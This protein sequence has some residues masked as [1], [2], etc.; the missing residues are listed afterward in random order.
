[1][2]KSQP[3]LLAVA[4][5]GAARFIQ[6]LT[7]QVDPL[8]DNTQDGWKEPTEA[9]SVRCGKDEMEFGPTRTELENVLANAIK[10]ESSD[11]NEENISLDGLMSPKRKYSENEESEDDSSI[12]SKSQDFSETV[13][14][15]YYQ[16]QTALNINNPVKTLK[17]LE[18]TP[19]ASNSRIISS[20]TENIGRHIVSES[21]NRIKQYA[22]NEDFKMEL[23]GV[24]NKRRQSQY[25]VVSNQATQLQMYKARIRELVQENR[26]LQGI[27]TSKLDVIIQ[28]SAE[29][30]EHIDKLVAR[31]KSTSQPATQKSLHK[32][33][34]MLRP[35]NTEEELQQLD[36]IVGTNPTYRAHVVEYL[37]RES[38]RTDVENLLH[39]AID[40]LF[41]KRFFL[42]V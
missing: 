25:D 28:N 15:M 36:E 13:T 35:L 33:V 7:E 1:M 37:K 39:D 20:S 27:I 40:L 6:V 31:L 12:T 2:K 4:G 24:N 10:I 30:N 11:F 41:C 34:F 8:G 32:T 42:L 9:V 23:D 21:Q 22:D 17:T 26:Y 18:Q 16:R 5:T 19:R 14:E 38:N 3:K 29:Q